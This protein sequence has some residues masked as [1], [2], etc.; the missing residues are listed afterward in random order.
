MNIMSWFGATIPT[1]VSTICLLLQAA[2]QSMVLEECSARFE[3]LMRLASE[4]P[5]SFAVKILRQLLRVFEPRPPDLSPSDVLKWYSSRQKSFL[6]WAPGQFQ[7]LFTAEQWTA[8]SNWGQGL[9]DISGPQDLDA[10]WLKLFS[11]EIL[12]DVV[13][14][15]S[16][17]HE[18]SF[19]VPKVCCEEFLTAGIA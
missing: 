15:D 2:L 9:A 11:L 3:K 8:S 16:F 7:R 10:L 17:P 6:R 18:V 13:P 12:N 19:L 14:R 5:E 4:N 1:E